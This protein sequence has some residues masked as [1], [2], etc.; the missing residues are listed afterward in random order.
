MTPQRLTEIRRLAAS[1]EIAGLVVPAA[2]LRELILELQ[3]LR[4]WPP[5]TL[6]MLQR[7]VEVLRATQFAAE[8]AA[9]P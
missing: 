7:D 2:A 9:S 6:E 3:P 5:M 1:C 4:G 8:G